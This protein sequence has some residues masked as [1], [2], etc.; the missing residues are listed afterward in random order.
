LPCRSGFAYGRN[1]S[2]VAKVAKMAKMANF[3][4]TGRM[5]IFDA[6]PHPNRP[7]QRAPSRGYL[8]RQAGGGET[9][10]K[11]VSGITHFQRMLE[12]RGE[13]ALLQAAAMRT[14]ASAAGRIAV[15]DP[16]S[17]FC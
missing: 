1:A 17:L 9:D 6:G 4:G 12:K 15:G 13:L 11:C 5:G 7:A 10:D 2:K 14:P 8:A 16:I 3:S